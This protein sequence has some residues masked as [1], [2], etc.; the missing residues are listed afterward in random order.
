MGGDVEWL[1]LNTVI[2]PGAS[3][4]LSFGVYPREEK[5]SFLSQILQ[6]KEDVPIKYYLSAKACAGFYLG[7]DR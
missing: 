1:E 6:K 4:M 5:E 2:L 7:T 3:S